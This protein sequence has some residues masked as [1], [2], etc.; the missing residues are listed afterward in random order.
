M[1]L[2]HGDCLVELKKIKEKSIDFVYLDLPYGQTGCKWDVKIDHH[3][4]W[5]E[6]KRIAKTDRTP[7]FFSCTTKF[8][9]ELFNSAPKGYFRWDLVWEKNRAAGFLN[10]YRLPMRKHEMVYCFAKKTPEYDVSSHKEYETVTQNYTNLEHTH[11]NSNRFNTYKLHK[12]P[13]PTSVLPPQEESD[14]FTYEPKANHELVYCFA[15]K[16]PEYDVSSHKELKYEGR[17]YSVLYTDNVYAGTGVRIKAGKTHK[18]PLPTSVLPPQEESDC[19]TYQPE[20]NHELVYCFAKKTPE[21]DVSSHKETKTGGDLRGYIDNSKMI[22]KMTKPTYRTT[23]KHT[24]PLP[25]SVLPPQED[26]ELVYCFAKKSPEYDVSSHSEYKEVKLRAADTE[27]YTQKN[28]YVKPKIHK[29]RLPSSVLD[30]SKYPVLDIPSSWCKYKCD[31]GVNHRTSKPVKLMEFLL[32]YWSK[33]GDT[34][35]DPTAGSGSMGVACKNMN[36]N[37]IGI[38]KDAEIFQIMKDRIEKHLVPVEQKKDEKLPCKSQEV[39]H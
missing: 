31:E 5:I 6:L 32:K 25:T 34:V 20:A 35:L 18:D 7:F 39:A 2:I 1:E 12:D 37:F 27:L 14:Y 29:D 3:A 26:H 17:D 13:L 24:D 10:A 19:F 21:Y 16:T 36:R 22:E 9:F 4:L 38:E 8:G 11:T 15:K 30:S 23:T 28:N 33:E